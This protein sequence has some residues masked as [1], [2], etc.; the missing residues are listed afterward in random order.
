MIMK[1]AVLMS[2]YNGEK[3]IRV[4]IESILE[5]RCDGQVDLIVRDDGSTDGTKDILQHYADQGKLTWYVGE[6]LAPAKSFL[7]L[8]SR[9]PGY[10]Y[11]AFCDQDDYWYPDK[12]QSSIEKLEGKEGPAMSLANA[13]LVDGELA[14]IGRN[15]YN[16]G[17]KRD[18]Y[19]VVCGG[20]ILGCTVMFNE[21]LAQLL[22]KYNRP[23]K[24]IMHD[25]YTA[26]LCTLFDGQIYYDEQAHMDYRQHGNNVEGSQWTKWAAI[27]NRWRRITTPAKVSIADMAGSILAQSPQA[28]DPEKLCFLKK[29]AAY[30]KSLFSAISLACS[31]KPRYN[32]KNMALT[33]RL[34][35]V[36]RNR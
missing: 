6:N 17:P 8:V 10:D 21:G 9:F 35:M 12:L 1:I 25:S 16:H 7:D 15:V 13:R 33:M 24:L 14:P 27:K 28:A 2:T 3:F 32:S 20:G 4:Q 5:Q 30:R 29:V 19:S 18:F 11:Y 31:R 26:I 34:A 23:D 36:L 22:R